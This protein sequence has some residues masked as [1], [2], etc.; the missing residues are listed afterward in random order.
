MNWLQANKKLARLGCNEAL[1]AVL[2]A[3]SHEE[4]P[5]DAPSVLTCKRKIREGWLR[6]ECN[7]R[8]PKKEEEPL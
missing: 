5:P 4:P 7:E 1:A 3:T 8:C 2:K 6:Y